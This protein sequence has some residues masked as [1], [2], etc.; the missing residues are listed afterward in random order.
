M[1]INKI[2][3]SVYKHVSGGGHV[4]KNIETSVGGYESDL[5]L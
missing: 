2:H 1:N 4:L 3:A 5:S